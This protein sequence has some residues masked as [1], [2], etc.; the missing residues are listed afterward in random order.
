MK[1]TPFYEFEDEPF[2]NCPL[3]WLE[4]RD[5]CAMA[6]MQPHTARRRAKAGCIPGTKGRCQGRYSNPW[7]VLL[8]PKLEAYVRRHLDES[9][10]QKVISDRQPNASLT[11]VAT[12]VN[13]TDL[14]RVGLWTMIER[15]TL[16]R[17]A[18]RDLQRME[19]AMREP[20]QSLF[21]MHNAM[22]ARMQSLGIPLLG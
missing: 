20:S 22:K 3:I 21:D 7:P 6:Q 13:G 12:V 8:T 19:K 18:R 5:F 15:R 16:D 1:P 14:V 17:L 2:G 4:K 9:R 10:R 11:P